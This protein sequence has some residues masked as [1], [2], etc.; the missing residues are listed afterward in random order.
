[1]PR[2]SAALVAGV[3][4]VTMFC[5]AR[6]AVAAVVVVI[7]VGAARCV[8]V[9][10]PPVV[11]SGRCCCA[12]ISASAV[13]IV[14]ISASCALTASSFARDPAVASR[15]FDSPIAAASPSSSRVDGRRT[16]TSRRM[17]GLSPGQW[18]VSSAARCP[19][20]HVSPLR[21]LSQCRSW[22]AHR[23]PDG[24]S[25]SRRAARPDGRRSSQSACESG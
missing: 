17:S 8:G 3:A 18:R 12:T 20:S 23:G 25:K 15:A 24:G 13:T 22:P 9:L 16:R 14:R 11:G 5:C 6:T 1:M 4:V 7:V 10:A 2:R 19:S 21:P